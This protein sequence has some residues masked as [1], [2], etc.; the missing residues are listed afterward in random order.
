MKP[1][2]EHDLGHCGSPS[3]LGCPS[4][5]A[6][7][8]L[9][10]CLC[11]LSGCQKKGSV[12]ATPKEGSSP[13]TQKTGSSLTTQIA[14]K[15]DAVLWVYQTGTQTGWFWFVVPSPLHNVLLDLQPGNDC[16]CLKEGLTGGS[17]DAPQGNLQ[18]TRTLDLRTGRQIPDRAPT[19]HI[20]PAELIP[21]GNGGYWETRVDDRLSV[22][23]PGET[24][25]LFLRVPADVL[26]LREVYPD[27]D[28]TYR[29]WLGVPMWAFRMPG[30]LLVLGLSQ[31][32][33]VCIDMKKFAETEH[34][35]TSP[36]LPPQSRPTE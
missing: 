35:A 30:D 11:L 1:D 34:S 36:S 4:H 24:G 16:V 27:P 19:K 25:E 33:V 15:H 3:A 22:Y 26:I 5:A 31:G 7:L 23:S 29:P 12:Q 6:G 14:Y 10:F 20:E 8:V 13:T 9:V 28:V 17:G 18:L 21:L 2:H 32:Y